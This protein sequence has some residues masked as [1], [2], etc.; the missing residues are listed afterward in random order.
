MSN[1]TPIPADHTQEQLLEWK[2]QFARAVPLNDLD[3]AKLGL[4][5]YAESQCKNEMLL[6]LKAL[7]SLTQDEWRAWEPRQFRQM[8]DAVTESAK[9]DDVLAGCVEEVVKNYQGALSA[10]NQHIH[11]L[12]AHGE[13]EDVT[14]L[15]IRRNQK[16]DISGLNDALEQMARLTHLALACTNRI[17]ELLVAGVL[18]EATENK[19][20]HIR[21]G[22]RWW[23]I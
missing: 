19:G 18:R 23:K 9:I 15:D 17:G 10:R 14:G 1:V 13:N 20:P 8:L 16:L 11:T 3:L 6:V 2:R 4:L 5:A 21:A 22:G 12:W 7:R